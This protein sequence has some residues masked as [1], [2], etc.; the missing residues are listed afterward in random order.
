MTNIYNSIS[1]DYKDG[2]KAA[3]RDSQIEIDALKSAIVDLSRELE[4]MIKKRLDFN[5]ELGF[6]PTEG[7][8]W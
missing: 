1:D 3:K 7:N 8:G 5:M 2:W 6:D 4:I